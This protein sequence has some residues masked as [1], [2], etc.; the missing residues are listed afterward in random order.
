MTRLH[1]PCPSPEGEGFCPR[2]WTVS[3]G[4]SSFATTLGKRPAGALGD[5]RHQGGTM[6][7]GRVYVA[8]TCDTKGDELRYVKR[9]IEAAGVPAVLVDL[10]TKG[11]GCAADV[12]ARAVAAH[13]P[14]GEGA[15]FTG[16]RGRSV[17]AMAVA[18]ERFVG[19]R[20]DVAGV[21]WVGGGGGG[22]AG[23]PAGGG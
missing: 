15:V 1:L 17:A 6:A 8:G 16:D 22:G 12:T 13:H 5:V 3:V 4:S 19:S 20:D 11:E 21:V 10:G 9:L 18:F 23:A 2:K 7:S 14:E